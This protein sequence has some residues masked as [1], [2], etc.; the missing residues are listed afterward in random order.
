M[1][2]RILILLLASFLKLLQ[3]QIIIKNH[4]FNIS[5]SILWAFMTLLGTK[6]TIIFKNN[7][8]TVPRLLSEIQ[9][10]DIAWQ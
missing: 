10:P 5:L 3:K 4:N 7:T 8:Y 2:Q 1:F 6:D 9:L